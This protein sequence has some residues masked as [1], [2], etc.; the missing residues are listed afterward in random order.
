METYRNKRKLALFDYSVSQPPP[1]FGT[2][3]Q[4]RFHM[5]R[6]RDTLPTDYPIGATW[7]HV[8][9][10]DQQ[11][12]EQQCITYYRTCSL[13]GWMPSSDSIKT[14]SCSTRTPLQRQV[15]LL[16]QM[17]HETEMFTCFV[18]NRAFFDIFYPL[19]WINYIIMCLALCTWRPQIRNNNWQNIVSSPLSI[20][21]CWY[22][23]LIPETNIYLLPCK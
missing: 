14:S 3:P 5:S 6:S 21:T 8:L 19:D 2:E 20:L 16:R 12:G 11:W 13:A 22:Q 10:N 17:W 7:W 18:Q 23:S 1:W 15:G 9:H 4:N